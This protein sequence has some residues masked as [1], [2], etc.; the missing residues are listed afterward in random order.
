MKN[1]S[2]WLVGL[3]FLLA[4]IVG[5]FYAKKMTDKASKSLEISD[6]EKYRNLTVISVISA[7]KEEEE[8]PKPKPRKKVYFV[9]EGDSI[10]RIAALYKILPWQLRKANGMGVKDSL[11]RLGQKLI[12]P[13]ISWKSY[14]G[15]AS[16]YGPGFHGKKMANGDI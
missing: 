16:W 6:I 3:F 10:N 15:R 5:S 7:E 13:K 1:L 12:I 2:L 4:V 14:V 8:K 9:K 11:L